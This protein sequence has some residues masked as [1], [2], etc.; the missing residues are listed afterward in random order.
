MVALRDFEPIL[1]ALNTRELFDAT[2]VDLDLPSIQCMEC[3]LLNGH[4]QATGCPVFRVAV[5]AD[6][7]K[8]L[9]P[10]IPFEVNQTSLNWNEDLADRTVAAAVDIDLPVALE[11]SQ[12]VRFRASQQVE[13]GQPKVHTPSLACSSQLRKS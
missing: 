4:L 2:M 11:L 1:A 13:I 6:R 5:C 3:G 12:P 10:A 8:N 9:D 7:P